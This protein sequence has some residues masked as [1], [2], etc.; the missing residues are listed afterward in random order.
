MTRLKF[1]KPIIASVTSPIVTK[2]LLSR[3][4]TLLDELSS[5]DQDT[6]DRKSLATIKDALVNRKL[7]R[8]ANAGVQAHVCCCI[9]DILRI[10]APDAPYTASELSMIFK[11]FF[12]QFK[13]LSN[14]ENP[15]F[16]Q[17]AYLLKRLAEVRSIILVTDLPDSES[18]IESIFNVFYDLSANSFPTRLEPLAADILAEIISESEVIP[19]SVLKL[20][21]NK[22]ITHESSSAL[23]TNSN[24][25]NPAFNFSVSIC[26]SN[27]DRM[28]RQV[29]KLF[30]EMIYEGIPETQDETNNNSNITLG[31]S[32]EMLDKLK[33]IHKLIV[34]IWKYV[35]EMLVAVMGLVDD[36]LKAEDEKIRILA[37]ETIGKMIAHSNSSTTTLV[38][39]V[40]FIV[41]HR[42]TWMSWLKKTFDVSPTV[43]CKWVEQIPIIFS[44]TNV[45]A[46]EATNELINGLTKC[47]LDTDERVRFTACKSLN[48]ISYEVILERVC[49]KNILNTLFQ[50]IREKNQEVR[51]EALKILGNLY[52]EYLTA[53]SKGGDE[54]VALGKSTSNEEEFKELEALIIEGIPN[55]IM[56][57][58]YI[59]DKLIT[60]TVDITIFEKLLPFDTNNVTRVGRLCQ[61]YGSLDEKAKSTFIA[62]TKRQQ[63]VSNVLEK[64]VTYAGSVCK[65]ETEDKENTELTDHG[66]LDSLSKVDKIISWICVSLPEGLN[67]YA[68]LERFYRLKNFRWFY[69]IKI[70]ISSES[71]YV[72]VKNSMKELL[73]KLNN[74][75][76]LKLDDDKTTISTT[77]MI[78]NLKLLMYRSSLIIY[79]KSNVV[80]LINYTKDPANGWYK[81]ANEL[82]E[83]ISV[84]VPEVF[85]F[86]VEELTNL[87]LHDD[88]NKTVLLKTNYH[89]IKKYP[90]LFPTNIRFTEKLKYL[91]INGSANE[92]K[93]A[94]KVIGLSSKREIMSTSIFNSIFPLDVQS[95]NLVVGLSSIA[96]LFLLDPLCVEESSGD[97]TSFIIKEILLKNREH[98]ENTD[99]WIEDL[100]L[101]LHPILLEKI[102]ALKIFVNRL[103]SLET[104]K[105]SDLVTV[106]QPVLKLLISLIGNGGEI[107]SEGGTPK[108]YQEKLRLTA[109]LLLLK[110]AKTSAFDELISQAS[111]NRLIFLLQDQNENVR[112]GFL[113]KLEK[114]LSYDLISERFL[115]L[116]Y[117]MGHEPNEDLKLGASTW[118]KS[119]YKRQATSKKNNIKFETSLL[120]LIHTIAHTLEFGELMNQKDANVDIYLKAYSY[121]LEFIV[122]YLTGVATSDNVSLLYYFASRIKQYRDA[123]VDGDLYD[124]NPLPTEVTNLYCVSELAQWIIKELCDLR[125]WTLQTWP[126]KVKLA[127][128]LFGP[129]KSTKEAHTIMSKVYI[130]DEVQSKLKSLLKYKLANFNKKKSRSSTMKLSTT[131]EVSKKRNL[132]RSTVQ[133]ARK[134]SKTEASTKSNDSNEPSRKSTRAKKE[135]TYAESESEADSD[136]SDESNESDFSD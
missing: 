31:Q 9:S 129:M 106:A 90:E 116:V 119:I 12:L 95:S 41:S 44:T 86:Q 29:A 76:N 35:P 38:N 15:Y 93:Y 42:D 36:E 26:E 62:I 122:L 43:R 128:D 107:V 100:Q 24:I 131:S 77:D 114:Y 115:P 55:H 48:K 28:S 20:V 7:L 53:K 92:A 132:T 105:E 110:L 85:K 135:V 63:Q 134:R 104:D 14:E 34:Q 84:V 11:T 32:F 125:G 113:K 46:V 58:V 91:A 49:N 118:V 89:F 37:T 98:C 68:C 108:A 59:N 3:L 127:T 54:V 78:S 65:T 97:I 109:G 136:E 5:I 83:N 124:V 47:L 56:A 74:L 57:L 80:E 96:E 103:R 133:R 70:C 23:T 121:A 66:K 69:L 18:L 120:R 73:T 2:E 71:D 87:V 33:K 112:I 13:K 19:P 17:Q 21:L 88:D 101:E 99:I 61:F 10:Y 16:Q 102:L 39:R 51:N 81:V 4:Q 111:I 6:I 30:S 123:T 126:G 8:H 27:V 94:I 60:S 25:S 64:F 22:L 52:N 130:S 82:L 50:L 79:N 1:N 75:K 45:I 40:S 117:F 67:S 72:S